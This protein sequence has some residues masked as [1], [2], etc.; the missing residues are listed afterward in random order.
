MPTFLGWVS[1]AVEDAMPDLAAASPGER[2]T[3][4]PSGKKLY[5][6]RP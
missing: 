2:L 3:G 4:R 6:W 1:V 5:T